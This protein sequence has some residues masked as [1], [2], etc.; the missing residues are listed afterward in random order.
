V[1]RAWL[2]TFGSLPPGA[3]REI[4]Y[5]DGKLIRGDDLSKI[6]EHEYTELFQTF[7]EKLM[8]SKERGE[9]VEVTVEEF[10]EFASML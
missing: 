1:E 3:T 6:L 4:K 9:A 8:E 2:K 7:K 10:S 5:Q